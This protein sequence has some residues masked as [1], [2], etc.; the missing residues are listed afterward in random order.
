MLSKHP[1]GVAVARGREEGEGEDGR[2][3]R[4]PR[5]AALREARSLT[6]ACRCP[7][8]PRTNTLLCFF[9]FFSHTHRHTSTLQS[10]ECI[11]L[12]GN[13]KKKRQGKRVML[14]LFLWCCGSLPPPPPPPPISCEPAWAYLNVQAPVKPQRSIVINVVFRF[15]FLSLLELLPVLLSSVTQPAAVM[16]PRSEAETTKNKNE[17]GT[18]RERD[19]KHR[20]RKKKHN[21]GERWIITL[22]AAFPSLS[23]CWLDTQILSFSFLALFTLPHTHTH[24]R[25]TW[26]GRVRHRF[27]CCCFCPA[28]VAV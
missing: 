24:T 19:I 13:Q 16:H 3:A 12:V 1:H 14:N 9:P 2:G 18:R 20:E 23:F 6:Y 15:F 26:S 11:V 4:E 27:A 28:S 5:S 8:L 10:T 7:H 22:T 21:K 17:T 25:L